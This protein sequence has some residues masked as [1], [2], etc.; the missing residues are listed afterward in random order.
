MYQ[1]KGISRLLITSLQ[2]C[3]SFDHWRAVSTLI[4]KASH[5]RQMRWLQAISWPKNLPEVTSIRDDSVILMSLVTGRVTVYQGHLNF[6]PCNRCSGL[7]WMSATLVNMGSTATTGVA[8]SVLTNE[9]LTHGKNCQAC[10]RKIICSLTGVRSSV[11][12]SLFRFTIWQTILTDVTSS[13][14]SRGSGGWWPLQDRLRFLTR[15]PR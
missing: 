7:V 11:W 6:S 13:N 12:G 2:A 1:E 9:K 5:C 15:G 14:A 3:T 8:A 4:E 10:F